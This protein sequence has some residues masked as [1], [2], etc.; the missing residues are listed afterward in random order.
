MELACKS[1]TISDRVIAHFHLYNADNQE[2][3]D[4]EPLMRGPSSITR[5]K[6]RE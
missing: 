3:D 4:R 2:M 5:A 1:I 6:R